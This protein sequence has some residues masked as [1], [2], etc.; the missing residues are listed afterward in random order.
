MDSQQPP[1]VARLVS[2][3]EFFTLVTDTKDT[4]HFVLDVRM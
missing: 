2:F 3:L 1:E 4:G